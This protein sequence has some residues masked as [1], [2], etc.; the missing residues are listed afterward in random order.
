VLHKRQH[1]EVS[2]SKC[3]VVLE[4]SVAVSTKQL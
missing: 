2:N 1:L 4:Q 3:L